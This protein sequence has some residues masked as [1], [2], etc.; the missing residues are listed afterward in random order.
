[1]KHILFLIFLMFSFNSLAQEKIGNKLYKYGN[2]ENTI[3]GATLISL[4][5]FDAKLKRK[6]IDYFSKA[7]IDAKSWSSL[8]IPGLESSETEF[9]KTLSDN[10]IKTLIFIEV[11]GQSTASQN[12]S[13]TNAYAAAYGNEARGSSYTTTSSVEYTAGLSIRLT[14]FSAEDNFAKPLGVIEGTAFNDWGAMGS[15]AHIARKIVR[16][17]ISAL[18]DEGAF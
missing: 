17:M 4:G 2:L 18:E 15:S 13:N 11:T 6:T 1:M 3:N 5:D 16:R 12:Y 7:G 10:D 8:F 9:N 14:V